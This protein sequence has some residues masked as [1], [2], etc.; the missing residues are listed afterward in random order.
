MPHATLRSVA[1]RVLPGLLSAKTPPHGKDQGKL[2]YTRARLGSTCVYAA[3]A[4]TAFR[5]RATRDLRRAAVFILMMPL[6]AAWSMHLYASFISASTTD[7]SALPSWA[8]ATATMT[9]G[10]GGKVRRASCRW[11]SSSGG[12]GAAHLLD[13]RGHL[14]LG[15]LV[16]HAR[17]GRLCRAAPRVSEAGGVRRAVAAGQLGFCGH[18]HLADP[19]ARVLLR[20]HRQR[21]TPAG[22][23]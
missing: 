11:K 22:G 20:L 4:S 7:D 1:A 5:V 2:L 6:A 14:A 21:Q 3:T 12:R 18:T 15:G 10:E 19:L 17:L 9:W 16:V 23:R 13:A 8:A